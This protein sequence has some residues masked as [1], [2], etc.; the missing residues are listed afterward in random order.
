MAR[1]LVEVFTD[2]VDG[3]E[4]DHT[5][6]FALDGV[7][8]E[9]DL[10]TANSNRMRADLERWIAAARIVRRDPKAR[11]PLVAVPRQRDVWLDPKTPA[12]QEEEAAFRRKVR[13][14]AR[15]AGL[16]VAD[17]GA[18]SQRILALYHDAMAMRSAEPAAT[19]GKPVQTVPVAA[20]QAA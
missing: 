12:Q 16:R 7:D 4:A 3:S 9:I 17:H 1:K 18:V 13:E 5:I 2:D 6:R 11:G 8:Y 19:N 14:W 15:E 10:S 20:F